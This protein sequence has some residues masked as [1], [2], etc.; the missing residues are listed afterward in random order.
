M[1]RY[2]AVVQPLTRAALPAEARAAPMDPSVAA[3][4][5]LW[6]M[7]LV[8]A[9]TFFVW[10]YLERFGRG[11]WRALT[12]ATAMWAGV[13]VIFWVAVVN[14]NLL[15]WSVAAWALPLAWVEMAVAAAIVHWGMARFR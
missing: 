6:D 2:V 15:P 13:F 12:A 8:I 9:A 10:L 5:G 4:W 1:A 3:L 14:M 11:L 7:L